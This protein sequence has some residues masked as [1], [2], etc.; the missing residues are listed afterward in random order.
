MSKPSFCKN[1]IHSFIPESNLRASE[2]KTATRVVLARH[3]SFHTKGIKIV[4]R[5]WERRN[6]AAIAKGG[7][8]FAAM[9]GVFV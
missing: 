5:G 3:N 6:N 7:R 8:G 1:G 4:F 2:S 9:L